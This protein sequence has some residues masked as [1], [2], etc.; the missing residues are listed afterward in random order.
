MQ[1][2]RPHGRVTNSAAPRHHHDG[3]EAEDRA[4]REPVRARQGK[5]ETSATFGLLDER[6]A[7]RVHERR[8]DEAD[9]G[10]RD[11]QSCC[12]E[13]AAEH[14]RNRNSHGDVDL[15]G[16]VVDRLRGAIGPC[17]D[18]VDPDDQ[19]ALVRALLSVVKRR[20]P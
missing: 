12:H 13:E 6:I 19:L 20:R 15:D 18:D 14:R 3:Q 11:G 16:Q 7:V 5:V 9:D 17:R 10:T 1:R 4:D 2:T 8:D